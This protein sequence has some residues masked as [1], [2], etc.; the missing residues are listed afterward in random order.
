MAEP[1]PPP[2]ATRH[3]NLVD[4]EEGT[5]LPLTSRY[6]VLVSGQVSFTK[7]E[8][9]K[10]IEKVPKNVYRIQVE[11]QPRSTD[12]NF[13]RAPWTLVARHF[14]STIQLYDDTAIIIRKKENTV[15]NKISSPEE[16][17]ENPD[18]FE[19]DY[20][21]DV[22]LK[23]EKSVTFKILIATRLPYWQTFR[24]GALFK[25]LVANDWYVKHMR[26]ENQGTVATIGHLLF[27]HNR[28]T[29]Q[30]DVISELRN[31]IYP[32]QCDQIDVRIT[33]SKEY[34][35]EGKKKVRAFTKWITIDCPV[36][37]ANKLSTVLMEKWQELQTNPKFK[38][39]NLKNTI[40]VP[41]NRGIVNFDARVEN[42]GKQN[43]FLRNYK[44]VTVLTNMNS[45]DAKF[46]YTKEIGKIFDEDTKI[47]QMLELRSFLLSWN[48]NSTGKPAIFAIHRTNNKGEYSLLSGSKNM[49]VIHERIKMFAKELN[50]QLGFTDVRVGGTKGAMNRF[51][52]S[53][54]AT[55]YARDNFMTTRKFNQKP[56]E[57][58]D[59]ND[60]NFKKKQ[61]EEENQWKSPPDI[62][63]KTIKGTKASLKLNYNDQ[64]LVQQFSDVVVGNSYQNNN[65]G[66]QQSAP[67]TGNKLGKT[68]TATDNNTITIHEGHQIGKIANINESTKLTNSSFQKIMESKQFQE[69]LAKA[70]APQVSQ[71]VTSLI[72]PTMEKIEH[73]ETQVG[74]LNSYVRGNA[75]WQETQTQQQTTIQQ[76]VSQFQDSMNQMQS[77]M[78]QMLT[79]FKDQKETEAGTKRPA[80]NINQIPLRSPTRRQKLNNVV[81]KKIMNITPNESSKVFDLENYGDEASQPNQLCRHTF[82]EDSADETMTLTDT[83]GEGEGQ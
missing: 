44:D 21:Y 50:N 9:I 58:E 49:V 25:K 72:A 48:D 24:E 71:Q 6:P 60:N 47:G 1:P 12:T 30:E 65:N 8:A 52:Q 73:I 17:P 3:I 62:N 77:T 75:K 68:I 74:D 61:Q 51:N 20:A 56:Q 46:R 18:D 14:L 42:I 79:I 54:S 7:E 33:K 19:R 55:K 37:I 15:A 64:R 82:S 28:Y 35:Y 38:N 53:N 78:N 59:N 43:E 27:A 67:T 32:T 63:R 34:Y 69:I 80:P 45:I 31:L 5:Q 76:D 39:Y 4:D 41:R 2:P 40:Y 26:L 36:D 70:V 16:L 66:Q 83:T 22:K 10:D 81:N 29:N 23:S 11:L 13:S 57:D